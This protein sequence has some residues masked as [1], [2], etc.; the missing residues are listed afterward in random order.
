MRLLT[1]VEVDEALDG[2]GEA[3]LSM[4]PV[5][6]T[7][8]ELA[9]LNASCACGGVSFQK[10]VDAGY[11]HRK[12]RGWFGIDRALA[13]FGEPDEL[14]Y[15]VNKAIMSGMIHIKIQTEKTAEKVGEILGIRFEGESRWD[16]FMVFE[17]E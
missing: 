13:E 2:N 7:V 9:E 3:G 12:V 5:E 8:V 14:D 11:G 17:D 15:S 1:K 6:T 4:I 16:G 10:A